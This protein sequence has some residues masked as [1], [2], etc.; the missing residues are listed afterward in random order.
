M[1][2]KGFV[3]KTQPGLKINWYTIKQ[4]QSYMLK[5]VKIWK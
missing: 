3:T 4:I 5:L 1:E 2:N